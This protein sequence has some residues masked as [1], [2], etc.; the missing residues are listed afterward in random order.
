MYKVIGADGN[1]YGPVPEQE[2]RRWIAEGRLNG[3]SRVRKEGDADWKP[4]AELPEFGDVLR[5]L[6]KPPPIGGPAAP[7]ASPALLVADILSRPGHVEIGACLSRGWR[8]LKNNLGLLLGATALVW[9]IGCVEFVPI[10][11]WLYNVLYGVL[12][13]G[14]FLVF[15]KKIRGE[16][17]ALSD[18][19]AGFNLAPGQLI[20]AGLITSLAAWVGFYCCCVLPGLYL[21]VAW[22]F[23]LPLVI[24]K[25]LEF[26]S[27]MELSRK[28][29]TR[30]WF[31]MFGLLFIAFLPV[32]LATMLSNIKLSLA[33]FPILQDAARS[34]QSDLPAIV[35]SIQRMSGTEFKLR[36]VTRLVLFFN[37]PFALAV[38][39]YAYEDLFGARRTPTA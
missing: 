19:F 3:Q 9:A 23:S 26:W 27:A 18:V 21:M 7:P 36:A 2:I 12:F 16:P 6:A 39:M 4:L 14:L 38:L 17:A 5:E 22:V 29:V 33:L 10:L 35:D 32:I 20:L 8:L 37:L 31:E 24:D 25:R 13:G 34:A 30:V 15:L 11:G 28:T 1:E